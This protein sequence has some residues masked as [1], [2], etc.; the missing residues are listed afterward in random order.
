MSE[1]TGKDMNN[2]EDVPA[3]GPQEPAG[4]DADTSA[5]TSAA[6]PEV[7]EPAAPDTYATERIAP[8]ETAP[9][10]SQA[11][12]SPYAVNET[13]PINPAQVTNE[14]R[15]AHAAPAWQAPQQT[16]TQQY[17]AAPMGASAPD[18]TQGGH[19]TG[20]GY[21]ASNAYPH[22][23]APAVTAQP[24]KRKKVGMGLFG[25]S[26]VA[27]ALVGALVAGGTTFLLDQQNSSN[28]ASSTSQTAPLIV[29]NT[30]S[31]NAVTAAAA[32][33]MPS[34]VT[35]SASSGSS[36]GTGSGI[37]LDTEGHIL[38]N[39]HVVTLDGAAANATISVQLSNGSVYAGTVVGTDPLSDLAI[40]KIDAPNL[41]PAVLGD[42]SAIN[43]GDN[44]VAIGA[45]LGLSGTVTDGIISTLNRTIQVASSAVPSTPSDSS[46]GGSGN[47]SGG[48]GFQFSPPDG[49]SGSSQ[50]A[51]GTV[52]LNVIQTDAA[53]NPGNSG[54]A[55]VN[56]QGQVIGVNVAIA[57]ASSSSSS[58]SQ[59]GNI[60][61]GFSIPIN[62]AKRI[63]QELI[64]SG[65]ASHGQLGVS[66]KDATAGGSSGFT[67]GAQIASISSGS[68]AGAAGLQTGDIIT[69]LGSETVS[70]ASSLTAAVRQQAG[71]ATVKV[72]YTRN[73]ETKTADVTLG[74]YTGS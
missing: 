2:S 47:G 13:Q 68:A 14:T 61:V 69:G 23:L 65:K 58:T 19:Y 44:V 25:G 6:A 59:S 4:Q 55:L 8:M 64:A 70:D 49:S 71:G 73:G 33:A 37:I 43:V 20:A 30:S 39:T 7:A 32:K 60:G 50:T 28:T 38:T 15:G 36:G 52:N 41:V 54:G 72:T 51:T 48:G 31:V 18:A 5:M 10:E 66:V 63:A 46:Q 29:N 27:A 56:A 3:Q 9:M 35:I 53:I 45:P 62:N 26:V 40:V 74:T 11:V 67:I 17:P 16:P 42:S 22:T 1:N 34:V 12:A 24:K 21:P 57:S